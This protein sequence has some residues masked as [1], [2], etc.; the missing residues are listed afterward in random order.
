MRRFPMVVID[1]VREG[2]PLTRPGSAEPVAEARA[3]ASSRAA[4]SAFADDFALARRGLSDVN[5]AEAFLSLQ[6]PQ[7]WRLHPE[8]GPAFAIV[9]A[10]KLQLARVAWQPTCKVSCSTKFGLRWTNRF[11][12]AVSRASSLVEPAP[13]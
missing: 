3:G 9:D 6:P 2:T 8:L 7:A 13:R 10:A 4:G 1:Q 11:P 5:R 12:G